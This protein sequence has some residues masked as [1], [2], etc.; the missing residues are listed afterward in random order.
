MRSAFFINI[1]I[2]LHENFLHDVYEKSLLSYFLLAS[3][4]PA[5][6][7]YFRITKI[8][9]YSFFVDILKDSFQELIVD[10]QKMN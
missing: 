7:S 9:L 10:Q 1:V 5:R 8:S 6:D 2:K 3:A 4:S